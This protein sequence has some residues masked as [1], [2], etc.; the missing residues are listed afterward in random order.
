MYGV[1]CIAVLL[2][3]EG[4]WN[5]K[6]EIFLGKLKCLVGCGFLFFVFFASD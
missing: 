5:G 2:T 3:L 6:E 1:L 4:V